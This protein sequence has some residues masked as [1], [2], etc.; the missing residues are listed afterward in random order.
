M[1]SIFLTM[2]GASVAL[3]GAI[4]DASNAILQALERRV[5]AWRLA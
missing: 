2:A 4:G 1:R 5:L 3:L